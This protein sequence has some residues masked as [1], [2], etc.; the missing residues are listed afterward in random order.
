MTALGHCFVL[1]MGSLMVSYL[2]CFG[3]SDLCSQ[4]HQ[5]KLNVLQGTE[6][7]PKLSLQ[8]LG[9]EGSS[10]CPC[11]AS[12]GQNTA[13]SESRCSCSRLCVE[14]LPRAVG[15]TVGIGWEL[16]GV[17]GLRGGCCKDGP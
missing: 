6:G 4:L 2:V 14:M 15:F 9:A 10:V 12:T 7:Q 16:D 13:G 3:R 1:A 5:P 17:K 8:H 11:G